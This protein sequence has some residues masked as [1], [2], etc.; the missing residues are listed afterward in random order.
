MPILPQ[1]HMVSWGLNDMSVTT[2]GQGSFKTEPFY[3][4]PKTGSFKTEPFYTLLPK[5]ALL[6]TT[7]FER[8]LLRS[9]N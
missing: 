2:F 8:L 7:R 5:T 3:T 9:L 6:R 1:V 4:L